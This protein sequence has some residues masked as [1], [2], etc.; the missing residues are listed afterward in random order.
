[1]RPLPLLLA[2]TFWLFG[3]QASQAETL[4]LTN[5][6]LIDGTGAPPRAGVSL[7]LVDGRIGRVLAPG[8]PAPAADRRIDLTG[9]FVIPGLI[10]THVHLKSRPRPDGVIEAVLAEALRGGVTTVRDMGG[11]GEAVA[12]LA[13]AE[14]AGAVSPRILHSMLVTG[15]ASDFWLRPEQAA[16]IGASGFRHLAS[17]ADIP[18]AIADARRLGASGIKLHSALSPDLAVEV[19]EAARAADLR[20]WS[21]GYLDLSRPSQVVAAGATTLSHSDMLAYE[22]VADLASLAGQPY[23]KRT[24]AAM[25]ATPLD[26][27]ALL[28]LFAAMRIRGVLLEPTLLVMGEGEDAEGRAYRQW[29]AEVVAAARRH[30]VEVCVGTDALGGSSP[31]IHAE[32]QLLV[33]RAGLTPLEAITAATR[34]GARALGLES[35]LGTVETGKRAD[36]VIPTADPSR[37][38]RNTL[39]VWA[40]LKD[41]RL[42]ERGRPLPIP[43]G[44][45]A[46]EK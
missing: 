44:A 37:D 11:N 45:E 18:A 6:T 15:P 25:R 8:Q 10:D 7:L 26:S 17:A 32:L 4:L 42:H 33:G 40:V 28:A 29:S 14:Q 16:Y 19:A 22:G 46:P 1:M 3:C 9:R 43:P 36:L 31:N 13:R 12:A 30:G 23:G 41:G 21:H 5:A 35:E 2:A 34:N 20:V 24:F 27:P 39:T 38:I